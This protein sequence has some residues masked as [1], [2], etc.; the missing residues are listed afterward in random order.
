MSWKAVQICIALSEKKPYIY[1]EKQESSLLSTSQVAK[2]L[3]SMTTLVF[4]LRLVFYQ[5]IVNSSGENA[6][7]F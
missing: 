4:V 2:Q 1:R 3:L 7:K 5:K 6:N